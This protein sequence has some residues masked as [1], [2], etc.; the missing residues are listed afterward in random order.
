MEPSVFKTDGTRKEFRHPRTLLEMKHPYH[1]GRPLFDN[2]AWNFMMLGS[3]DF[4]KALPLTTI[5][6]TLSGNT[7]M[8]DLKVSDKVLSIDGKETTILGVFP[9][10]SR[11]CY[12]L[13]FKDGR[14]IE[15]DEEHL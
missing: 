15:A 13:T 6:P 14:T 9:Q 10:G 12:K 4:G 8:G 11:P 7:L 3:R 5:I 2:P 1:K